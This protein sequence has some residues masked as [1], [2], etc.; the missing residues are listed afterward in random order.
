ML[1]K[2]PSS[3]KLC[4]LLGKRPTLR[5]DP[6]EM[7]IYDLNFEINVEIAFVNFVPKITSEF[8]MS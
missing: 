8:S 5:A 2:H 4:I 7:H 1:N 3:S 6:F